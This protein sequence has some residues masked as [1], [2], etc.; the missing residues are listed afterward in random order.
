MFAFRK[1]LRAFVLGADLS[2]GA[3]LRLRGT[4]GRLFGLAGLQPGQDF[5]KGTASVGDQPAAGATARPQRA[6]S[7]AEDV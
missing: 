2:A 3:L 5:S 1:R 6:R 7:E 4:C